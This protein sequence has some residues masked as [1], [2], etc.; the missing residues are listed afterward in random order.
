MIKQ[1]IA[2]V[3]VPFTYSDRPLCPLEQISVGTLRFVS[4]LKEQYSDVRFINMRSEKGYLWRNKKAGLNGK[5]NVQM[6]IASKPQ[7]YLQ[8]QLSLRPALHKIL[9]WCDFSLSPYTFDMDAIKSLYNLCKTAQPSAEVL[10]GGDYFN[11][12]PEAAK[13]ENYKILNVSGETLKNYPPDIKSSLGE[14]YALFQLSDGCVNNCSFCVASRTKPHK[15]DIDET[16]DY[17]KYLSKKGKTDFLCWDQNVLLYSDHLINFLDKLASLNINGKLSFSLGFQP[18]KIS[19]ELIKSLSKHKMGVVTI[20]FETGTV[21]SL[22]HVKKPYTIIS[23]IK[24]TERVRTA[25][26]KNI[27]RIQSSFIIGYTHDDFR[28]IFRIFLSALRLGVVPLPFPLY[29]FP[30]TSEYKNNQKLLEKKDYSSLHGQLYPLVPDN[31]VKSYI[32]L[33]KFLSFSDLDE[34]LKNINLLS[35]EMLKAFNE[36]LRINELFVEKCLESETDDINALKRIEKEIS[37]ADIR[38]KIL[39]IPCSPRPE[40]ISSSRQVG[41]YF[42]DEFLKNNKKYQLDILDLSKNKPDFIN[43]EY[44]C[45]IDK[46]ITYDKL[47]DYTKRLVKLTDDYIFRLRNVEIIVFSLPMY[48][49]S[50]PSVLKCFFELTAS[51]LFYGMHNKLYNKKICCVLTRDG[52]YDEN[53]DMKSVQ[54]ASVISAC[55]FIGLGDK[56]QFITVEGLYYKKEFILDK[57]VK[58]KVKEILK[59]FGK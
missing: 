52:V 37:Q 36:E 57:S 21:N 26:G 55:K 17:L 23:A 20:P 18:D 42:I 27:A 29:V 41:K 14:N 24:A 58:Q 38:K 34:A 28:S 32:N 59:M 56:V 45:F 43:D 15:Y 9:L 7:K 13:K 35:K 54:E 2:V 6:F 46:K 12:F 16:I 49:L 51:R 1:N 11:L 22:N 3:T 31:Q 25:L 48:T 39:Y 4:M 44:T 10:V 19:D 30:N 8:E 53:S 50:I 5:A 40:N 33:L 47:S